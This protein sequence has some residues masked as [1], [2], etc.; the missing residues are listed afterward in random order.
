MTNYFFADP[1]GAVEA[2]LEG[3]AAVHEAYCEVVTSPLYVKGRRSNPQR[4]VG[5][6][7][8][9]GS[10]HEPMH[11][12]FIGEGMLDAAAPGKVFA[13]PHNRQVYEASKAAA[14]E[15]GVLHI[16][17]NY[18]G[19][20]IN[21]GIAAERLAAE[22]INVARVLIDDDVATE[23]E[24]TA[25]GRRGTG[26]TVFVEKILGAAAD[27]GLSLEELQKLGTAVAANSRS[28]AVA[29]E[30]LTSIHT[31]ERVFELPA[32]QIEYGIGIHGERAQV[33]CKREPLP[34]LIN[35]MLNDLNSSLDY[36]SPGSTCVVFVNGL[37]STTN[38]E[39]YAIYNEVKKQLDAAGVRIGG[40]LVGTYV[41]ALDM[42]GFSLSLL[43]VTDPDWINYWAATA[44]TPAWKVNK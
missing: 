30:A 33:T 27:T 13:S 21:F 3:F 31:G 37:G 38:L 29:S 26:S 8:G 35:Q 24:T 40:A 42:R 44:D 5:L 6:V 19:D 39:L 11:A 20:R 32:D 9:G 28:I 36:R 1:A 17:K 7:S 12:G 15:D 22:G 10:G 4:R 2:S 41:S 43:K 14:C 23:S 18:T 16:V 34:A 25:T